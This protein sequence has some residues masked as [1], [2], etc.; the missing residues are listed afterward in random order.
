MTLAKETMELQWKEVWG[1]ETTQI[2]LEGDMIVPDSK[3]D[4]RE[5]LRCSTAVRLRENRVSEER[6]SFAGEAEISV[7]YLAKNG[8]KPLYAMQTTLPLE[9]VLHMEGLRKDMNVTLRAET[10]HLDC[11]II[12][13]RKLA[14]KLIL[15]VEAIAEQEKSMEILTG[16]DAPNMETQTEIL[17]MERQTTEGK[18]RFTIREE[19]TLPPTQPEISEVLSQEISLT[20][21][22]I[23]PMD[24][25]ALVRG[26]LWISLLY[27]DAEGNLGSLAEKLPFSG[28]LENAEIEPKTEWN[29]RLTIENAK[30][31]PTVDED[32]E[33]RQLDIDVTIGASLFGRETVEREILQDAYAP[34]E[35]IVLQKEEI[36]YPVSIGNGRS[37][38]TI[39][40]K[41]HLEK[42]E[43][44][45][46]R[47]EMLWGE[48]RLLEAAVHTDTVAAEGV[49][50]VDML[51]HCADDE[52]PMALLRRDIP[53]MQEM[54]VKGAAE[55]DT[56]RVL[57]RLEDMDV[58][59]LSDTEGEL[60]AVI[61][62]EAAV[63]RQETAEVVTDIAIEEGAVLPPVA[64]AVIYQVQKGDTL[65][66]IAKKYRTTTADIAAV[67]EIENPDLI[68][69]GQKL[70]IIKRHR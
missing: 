65:W 33:T 19:L 18:D 54:E 11:Q 40:E 50:T 43:M 59:M 63:S 62:M 44:P 15:R 8:E 53:F 41:I 26:N 49:L 25:K 60:R 39:K 5:I 48:V 42:G 38:F 16:A 30:L 51:Y 55:G 64:G 32:G 37:Q 58:Q 66:K 13:D 20:E 4:L 36:T 22:E 67:N 1:E 9:D 14:V 70:L 27:M 46:L 12:N 45:M 2:L 6:V 56:V 21:Q 61:A 31:T 17:R 10:E 28:Y 68:Y 47:T 52:A 34:E 23:R 7:L 29:G 35:S 57:L 24:G 3:P 69:P